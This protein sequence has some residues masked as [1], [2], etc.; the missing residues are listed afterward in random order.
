M[1]SDYAPPRI[2]PDALYEESGVR[3]LLG[4]TEHALRQGR[5]RQGLRSARRGRRRFYRGQ[6]LIDWLLSESANAGKDRG[7]R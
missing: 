3:L 2:D 7:E 5:T 6:W 1:D 4:L